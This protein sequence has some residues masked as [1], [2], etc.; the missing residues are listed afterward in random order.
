MPPMRVSP[1]AASPSAQPAPAPAPYLDN[2][3]ASSAPGS[4]LPD[5][6][7]VAGPP[8]GWVPLM[9]ALEAEILR[10]PASSFAVPAR[11]G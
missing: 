7:A 8:F 2:S 11:T 9:P 10:I 6:E 3:G 1:S 5:I 4:S